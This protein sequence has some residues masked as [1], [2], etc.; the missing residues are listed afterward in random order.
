MTDITGISAV[1]SRWYQLHTYFQVD[2]TKNLDR[3]PKA[4]SEEVDWDNNDDLM[5]MTG[6]LLFLF[7]KRWMNEMQSAAAS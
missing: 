5:F 2:L 1:D 6:I 4:L 3:L 7:P